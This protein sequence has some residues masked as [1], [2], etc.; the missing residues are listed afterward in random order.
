MSDTIRVAPVEGR[1]TVL[2]TNPRVRIT[3]ERD[4]PNT[5]YYRRRIACGDLRQ[6]DPITSDSSEKE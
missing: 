5:T 3:A 6:V 4:V 2:E 1:T